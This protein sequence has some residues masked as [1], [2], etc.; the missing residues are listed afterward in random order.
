MRP[1]LRKSLLL[2]GLV[3]GAVVVTAQAVGGPPAMLT[4]ACSKQPGHRY[5]AA[6]KADLETLLGC[7]LD[8]AT[9]ALK[10]GNY[11]RVDLGTVKGL[12]LVSEDPAKPASFESIN[13]DGG[14]RVSLSQLRFGGSIEGVAWRVQVIDSSAIDLSELDITGRPN[15]ASTV[16]GGV[17]V[18]RSNHVSLKRLKVGLVSNG[19]RIFETHQAVVADNI[20]YD[21][22]SDGMQISDASGSVI[23]G[24]FITR[25]HPEPGDHPDG[26]QMYTVGKQT[27]ASDIVIKDN[28]IERGTGDLL[29]GIFVTDETDKNPFANLEIANNIVLGSMYHGITVAGATSGAVRGNVVIPLNG[30]QN[31]IKLANAGAMVL[32]DNVAQDLMRD[33]LIFES[34]ADLG[35]NRRK[36]L[37]PADAAAASSAWKA[38]HFPGGTP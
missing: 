26:I 4:G 17:Y 1:D 37:S 10:P 2:A 18:H 22:G 14:N 5:V 11:G 21:F 3:L 13:I 9:I 16:P 29:Q 28:L 6:S 31:W 8:G 25:A 38:K 15:P 35:S 33:K 7:D 27:A 30:Q 32:E 34:K 24:N 23:S 36:A 20:I 19:L 12:T